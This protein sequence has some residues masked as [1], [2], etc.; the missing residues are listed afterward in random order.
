[1]DSVEFAVVCIFTK[2]SDSKRV[3]F[4][5]GEQSLSLYLAIMLSEADS[6]FDDAEL[7]HRLP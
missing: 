6:L 2:L 5:C 7:Y 4:E 3:V 1:M